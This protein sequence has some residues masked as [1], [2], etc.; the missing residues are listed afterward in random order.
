MNTVYQHHL[1]QARE[2]FERNTAGHK[3][4]VLADRSTDPNDPQPYRHL[5]LA[6][7]GTRTY[8]WDIITWPGHLATIGDIADGYTF[9]RVHD[10]VD[11]FTPVA[12]PYRINPGYWAEKL[13]HSQRAGA[14]TFSN[15]AL[16][17]SL[18][19]YI[20]E[21]VDP[22]GYSSLADWAEDDV[23][24]LRH[25][26]RHD[27]AI[28]TTGSPESAYRFL[29]QWSFQITDDKQLLGGAPYGQAERRFSFTETDLAEFIS[30]AYLPDHHLLLAMYAI[31]RGL[32]M[33]REQVRP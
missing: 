6:E 25:A 29:E 23:L 31:T 26:L 20:T 1:Q 11:F 3:L 17:E 22:G 8:S 10:M 13:A 27:L 21:A 9:A 33:Y 18:E 19:E 2:Q 24:R 14:R 30:A 7:P 28:E 5:R 4:T 16:L 12:E 32:E 15:D